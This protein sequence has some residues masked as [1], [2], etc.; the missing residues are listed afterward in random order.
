MLHIFLTKTG[1][2]CFVTFHLSIHCYLSSVNY[3]SILLVSMYIILLI[4]STVVGYF[5][6]LQSFTILNNTHDVDFILL[7]FANILN[8]FLRKNSQK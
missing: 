7:I 1:S 5:D 3:R 8:C 6:S 4:Q 2:Y